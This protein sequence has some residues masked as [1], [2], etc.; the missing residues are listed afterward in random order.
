[1][2]M[3]TPNT[4]QRREYKY[5]IDEDQATAIKNFIQ[6]ICAIDPYAVHTGGKY[7]IDT[8]YLDTPMFHIYRAT[9]E[10][11]P[12]RY[13]LRIRNYPSLA[14]GPV[15]FEVKRRVSDSILKTR[16][17]FR[18]H[19]QDILIG[20][21]HDVLAHIDPKQRKGID[22]FICHY[23]KLPMQ[24]TAIVRYEREPYF[25]TI[26]EYARITFDRSVSYQRTHD[27]SLEAPTDHWTY[28]DDA[29]GQRGMRPNSSAVLLELKF[30][31]MVPAW[32][33]NMVNTIGLQRLAF[34]KYS[35][36][37][38]SMRFAPERRIPRYGLNG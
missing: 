22:N 34:C 12:D 25:S 18:G 16:G 30:T 7:L 36:A 27:L 15:F 28:I 20:E 6:G 3:T 10:D 5:L 19:W 38:D 29:S 32:M 1:M 9:I 2:A 26:D 31:S 17:H 8:L 37:I 11:S 21:S 13:K 24:P 35:R 14:G 33:R 4:L 23:H